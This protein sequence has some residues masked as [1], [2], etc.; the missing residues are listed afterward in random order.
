M[1]ISKQKKKE[2]LEAGPLAKVCFSR[3]SYLVCNVT[4]F[5]LSQVLP[6]RGQKKHPEAVRLV[7]TRHT[8][9]FV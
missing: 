2:S 6:K 8:V 7:P 3:V 9:E 1:S 4:C 5:L